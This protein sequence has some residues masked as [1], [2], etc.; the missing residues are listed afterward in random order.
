MLA[1][2]QF[3]YFKDEALDVT[4]KDFA[5]GSKVREAGVGASTDV[6]AGAYEHHSSCRLR[7]SLLRVRADGPCTANRRSII[8]EKT[9][10]IKS[11]A[12]FKG[13]KVCLSAPGSST[14]PVLTVALCKAGARRKV[15]S[16]IG[17]GSG[18]TVIYAVTNGQ[19]DA[20]LNVDPMMT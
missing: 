8:K 11:L 1:A 17:V 10:S 16:A 13:A 7:P 18:A 9:G 3:G 2:K 20:L 15:I 6:G 19:V 12:D 5:G 14:D 4:V